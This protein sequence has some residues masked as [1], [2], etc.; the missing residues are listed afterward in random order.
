MRKNL[1]EDLKLIASDF[2]ISPDSHAT[3]TNSFLIEIEYNR[4]ISESLR[5][6]INNRYK[7]SKTNKTYKFPRISQTSSI[8]INKNSIAQS[9]TRN[10]RNEFNEAKKNRS[11]SPYENTMFKSVKGKY[12]NKNELLNSSKTPIPMSITS[13]LTTAKRLPTLNKSLI[14]A[15]KTL[16]ELRKPPIRFHKIETTPV[17]KDL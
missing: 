17:V 14:V 10:S 4:D 9:H 6:E 15:K 8:K 7:R 12:F 13:K 5:N 1:P 3:S 16:R 2:G 11:L